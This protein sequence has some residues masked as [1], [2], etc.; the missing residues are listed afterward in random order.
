MRWA[1]C[2]AL[3]SIY[4]LISGFSLF[5]LPIKREFYMERVYFLLG[6]NLDDRERILSEAISKMKLEIGELVDCSSIYETEP[7]GFE[8]ELNFLNQVVVIETELE[9]KEILDVTQQIEK[10]LGRVRKKD[11][12]SE[13][14]I[15][16]DILFYGDQ[17]ISTD[18]LVVP[19]P[20]VQERL[21]ALIPMLD[22]APELI[23]PIEMKSIRELHAV[24]P[25][26]MEVKKFK[27]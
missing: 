14:T 20:R 18:R 13:R 17:I 3:F 12:Y 25:D 11:Q 16:I 15:D 19:H 21:F 5:L 1:W 26:K 10:D 6:G 24:C 2:N 7:W 27:H 9:A 4:I 22:V 23:H 8:H